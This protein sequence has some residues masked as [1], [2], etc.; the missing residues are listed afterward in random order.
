MNRIWSALIV[1]ALASAGC[2]EDEIAGTNDEPSMDVGPVGDTSLDAT[3]DGDA[4]PPDGGADADAGPPPTGCT[5][6]ADCAALTGGDPCVT[7]WCDDASGTCKTKLTVNA[8]PCDDGNACTEE[9]VCFQGVCGGIS[10]IGADPGKLGADCFDN[11]DCES[12]FCITLT[13]DRQI[14]TELCLETCPKG[15]QCKSVVN[16]QQDVVFICVPLGGTGYAVDCDDENPCTTD[17]CLPEGGCAHSPNQ[18]PCD[19]GNTCTEGDT[20]ANGVCAGDPTACGCSTDADCAP[21]DDGNLCNGAIRCI[22]GACQTAPD[23][24]VKCPAAA[25]GS[26]LQPTCEPA[27]GACVDAPLPDGAAC[28][29]GNGCTQPDKCQGGVCTGGANLCGTCAA[30]ADCAAF[31]DG[32]ACNGTLGCVEG[33]CVVAAGSVPVCTANGV[34]KAST[35]D[36]TTGA[37]EEGPASDGAPCSDGDPC[38]QGDVCAAG[39][40]KGGIVACDPCAAAAD[41][42]TCDDGNPCTAGE[43]CQAGVCAGGTDVCAACDG[44]PEGG[45]C[46]DGDTCTEGDACHDGVCGGQAYVC[47]DED[48][49]T[50]DL[51]DGVGGCTFPTSADGSP[52]VDD[53]IC[54]TDDVC[55]AGACASGTGLAC[56]DGSPCT[57]DSCDPVGGCSFAPAD[58]GVPCDDGN[59]C[60]I[61]D[62]C[63]GGS[64]FGGGEPDCDDGS[65]CT[66]DA[67]DLQ[68]GCVHAEV[69]G[70]AC[71]DGNACS[72]GDACTSG[73]CFPGKP[74]PCD[75]GNPC[76]DDAC[77]EVA[78]CLHTPNT[79]PCTDG[80]DCTASDSCAAGACVSGPSIC[81][82][83][84]DADCAGVGG[85]LCVGTFVCVAN[86]PF[87]FCA[88]DPATV[89]SCPAS[90]SPCS[91]NA[92]DPQTGACALSPVN[93]GSACEDGDACTAL[94]AC[95]AGACTG[96][97]PV[98]CD[99]G[100]P[101]TADS[102]DVANGCKAEALE[103]P[104]DDGNACTTGDTCVAGACVAAAFVVC[105]DGDPCTADACDPATGCAST[106]VDAPCD[107]G[108]P[109]TVGDA[110]V[111]GA[112]VGGA[113][114]CECDTDADC[115]AFDD[116]NA[117]NGVLV[118]DK[119]GPTPTCQIAAGSVVTCD[120]G[121]GA[122]SK[123]ACVPATGLC[124]P[125]ALPDGAPCDDGDPCTL[126]DACAAGACVGPTAASCDDG[127]PCTADIC[128]PAGCSYAPAEGPCDDSNPCTAGDACAAGACVGGPNQCGCTTD[129]DCATQDDG[130]L[131]NGRLICDTAAAV[132]ACILDVAS[133]VKCPGSDNPCSPVVCQPSTGACVGS[134][135][136]E[137][138][139]CDDGNACTQQDLCS[140][141]ACVGALPVICDD[142]STCTLDTCSPL[143]GCVHSPI[144]APCEDGDLCTKGDK[145]VAGAC[146]PGNN[147]CKCK[148]DGDCVKKDDGNACNGT[149]ICAGAA[150]PGKPKKTSG[151]CVAAPGTVVTC[152][153]GGAYDCQ[154]VICDPATGT[155]GGLASADGTACDDGDACSFGDHC[156]AGQCLGAA[157][158]ACD[159]AN[160]CT[161]D[162]CDP[163]FGCVHTPAEGSC[164]DG[165]A[166]T[167]GEACKGG[168]CVP[169]QNGCGCDTTEDCA[170]WDDGD[171]CNGTLACANHFCAPDPSTVVA[172][173]PTGNACTAATC[174]PATGAC[175]EQAIADG[176]PC[177]DLNPCTWGDACAAGSCAP[178]AAVDCDDQ[179]EC[180]DDAC[181]A[182]FGCV[183]TPR[184]G[185]CD[186]GNPCAGPD[187]CANGLCL[188]K[189]NKCK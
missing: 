105:D 168:V 146:A 30:D 15:F 28:S 120:G 17:A 143:T 66:D 14:C 20:C 100:N 108:N 119:S 63:V 187:I 163:V 134:S 71:D 129:D 54:S 149:Y 90:S 21:F 159:D 107:D 158:L 185:Q 25:T 138:Q 174:N 45:S 103:V 70:G 150:V 118:C 84:T 35:C 145:C 188:P 57:V 33:A 182:G 49:C 183:Y 50:D 97:V 148:A 38:T 101:C 27:T 1:I 96:G 189:D 94:S 92:C 111:E 109:C 98:V 7:A 154:L 89:V 173:A 127:N 140:S 48:P 32:N 175:E 160:P 141:G 65:P 156:E 125:T 153:D 177:S 12:G 135:M 18:D 83:T 167:T 69:S 132:P 29:D 13:E 8:T 151:L 41:G 39:A 124:E 176:S 152:E 9:T 34:C 72:S 76:T 110:C 53:D 67:C 44:V 178:G 6:E 95:V 80:S 186:D 4:T 40:C 51:C 166:C 144:S 10:S 113:D 181:K 116:G 121:G 102:C 3:L 126:G 169:A 46:D 162:A 31:D 112:C 19:D 155:C 23:S 91:V 26:C 85:N 64:C 59:F 157:S 2:A 115:A 79:A 68:A 123:P 180:T 60:T 165:L 24:V 171:P 52:C 93:E 128:G 117:C 61:E 78:G 74:V 104:C 179:N 55:V 137:G 170:P 56:D 136:A 131:C 133:V 184:N 11:N 87:S 161:A 142:G 172:C 122:C 47:E 147:V 164:D 82:C 36:P 22:E 75:D 43:A 5:V 114:L 37:C 99:D 58:F 42:T 16:L 139:P 88:P 106:P 62:L 86:G 81:Q 73:V 130:D 77:D